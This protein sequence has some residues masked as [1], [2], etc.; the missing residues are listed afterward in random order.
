MKTAEQRP[1]LCKVDKVDTGSLPYSLRHLSKGQCLEDARAL[2]Y[3]LKE[4]CWQA[5]E[6]D[7]VFE[8]WRGMR[9]V[10]D[11]IQDKID[12]A[13]GNYHFPLSDCSDA[14]ALVEREDD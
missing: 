1:I 11:L 3:L 9:H 4:I 7:S 2:L 12:I 6:S 14:P 10:L 5:P 8:G 13:N